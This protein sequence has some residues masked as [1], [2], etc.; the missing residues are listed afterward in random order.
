[1]KS[2]QKMVLAIILILYPAVTS[3]QNW[4]M[5]QKYTTLAIDSLIGTNWPKTGNMA[6]LSV[7]QIEFDD[8]F[9]EYTIQFT[10]TIS[11]SKLDIPLKSG[12][13]PDIVVQY[14]EL[15]VGLTGGVATYEDEN[16]EIIEI[17][18]PDLSDLV[19]IYNEAGNEI[20][21][22]LSNDDKNFKAF[23]LQAEE[24]YY[25]SCSGSDFSYLKIANGK[26]TG[27]VHY[28]LEKAKGYSVKYNQE[29]TRIEVYPDKRMNI[30]DFRK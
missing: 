1:M 7:I 23:K 18:L 21:F 6:G 8:V 10:D 4:M 28:K 19:F 14:G 12:E 3:G 22:S 15:L 2:V 24:Y 30:E 27:N 11:C 20:S 25:F 13:E 16:G 17:E 29:K 26:E 5:A 9:N